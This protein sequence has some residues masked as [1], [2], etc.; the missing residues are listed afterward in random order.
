[1]LKA[2]DAQIEYIKATTPD[3]DPDRRTVLCHD[4]RE[5]RAQ[6]A[7]R[8][9]DYDRLVW[10]V[11][12]ATAAAVIISI[13]LVLFQQTETGI[14]GLLGAIV[15]GVAVGWLVTRR[16]AARDEEAEAWTEVEEHCDGE[17]V[18]L[19]QSARIAQ[20]LGA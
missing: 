5:R 8:F 7:A 11:G 16:N 2:T 13:G 10:A 1:V 3:A 15:G 14:A 19:E 6:A 12:V 18:H 9:H 17:L 4:A 20:R